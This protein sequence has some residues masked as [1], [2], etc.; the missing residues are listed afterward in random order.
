MMPLESLLQDARYGIRIL[1]VHPGFTAVAV[2][3]LSLG[4]GAAA[5][6]F[7]V[8]DA[9]L[10]RP[11]AVADPGS[12]RDVRGSVNFGGAGAHKEVFGAA[13]TPVEALREAADFADV[14]GFR[15]VD[16]VA[17]AVEGKAGADAQLTRAE[18][19]SPEYFSVLGLSARAGRLLDAGDRGP[20]PVP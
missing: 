1:R 9:V 7:S 19:V 11:L 8:A 17:V 4:L 3:S 15:T 6:V 10:F 18:F 2:L 5:A 20:S 14:I 13:A 12:L 16:D